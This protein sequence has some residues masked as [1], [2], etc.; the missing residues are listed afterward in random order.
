MTSGS[1]G[2]IAEEKSRTAVLFGPPVQD[3]AITNKCS[4]YEIFGEV[5]IW[6]NHISVLRSQGTIEPM[7][8]RS[9]NALLL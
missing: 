6:R 4:Y 1:V 3:K 5:P 8:F 7:S 2:D 9:D